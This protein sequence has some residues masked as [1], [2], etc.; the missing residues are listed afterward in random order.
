MSNQSFSTS[1][2]VDQSP[3]AVYDAI[4]R[5]ADWWGKEIDGPVAEVGDEWT[6][7]YKDMHRSRQRTT[8]LVP[9][10]RIVWRVLESEINFLKDK[11][12]WGG[13]DL[14]FEIAPK[15]DRTELRF[16]H[17]GLAP[18]VECYDI[19]TGGWTGLIQGSLKGLIENGGG[20]PDTV[21][22]PVP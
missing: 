22:E 10:Q 16:T 7:R 3:S 8:E 9:D 11:N 15:G 14:V 13:T 5:P 4:L 21:E 2:V 20:R 19:C 18:E 1:I 6:Y 17:V 12:E